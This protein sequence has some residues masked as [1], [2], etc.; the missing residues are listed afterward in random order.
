MSSSAPGFQ[1]PDRPAQPEPESAPPQPL[2]GQTPAGGQP[3]APDLLEQVLRQTLEA[4]GEGE[5]MDDAERESLLQVL[6]RHRGDAAA[7]EVVVFEL[8]QT[9]LRAEFAGLARS[10]RLLEETAAGVAHAL[11]ADPAANLRLHALRRRFD[12]V[13]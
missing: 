3:L 1:G 5:L 10:P 7:F 12:E 8:V 9:I 4:F 2:G 11:L 6:R 13:P